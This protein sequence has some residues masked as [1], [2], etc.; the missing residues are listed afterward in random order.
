MTFH[1]VQ[2]YDDGGVVRWAVAFTILPAASATPHQHLL[3]AI[4]TAI[5][6]LVVIALLLFRMRDRRSPDLRED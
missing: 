4:V 3:P 1:A 5:L 2:R 6:G